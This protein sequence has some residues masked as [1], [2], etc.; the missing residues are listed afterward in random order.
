M[1]KEMGAVVVSNEE[2]IRS[3]FRAQMLL[4]TRL[5]GRLCDGRRL[6]VNLSRSFLRVWAGFEKHVQAG[7]RI[8]WQ[9]DHV[10]SFVSNLFVKEQRAQAAEQIKT[11]CC[12][13]WP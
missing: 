3:G 10:F 6:I 4:T 12:Q 9:L 2:A 13:P 11:C 1:H 8:G 5:F 7:F